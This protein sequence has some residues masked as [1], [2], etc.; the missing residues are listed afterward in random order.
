MAKRNNLEII[1]QRAKSGG[2]K[3]GEHAERDKERGRTH[4]NETTL[5]AQDHVLDVYLAWC[6]N[7]ANGVP[8]EQCDTRFLRTFGGQKL[9]DEDT[10]EINRWLKDD[11]PYEKTKEGNHYCYNMEK[12]KFN[13]QPGDLDRLI[14]QVWSGQDTKHIHDKNRLQFH[15][16]LLL[17][18]QSGARRGALLKY[19]V[20]YKDIHLVLS[21]RQGEPWFF[22]NLAQRHV[23]NNKDPDLRT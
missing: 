10:A 19:G 14:D 12:P 2:Y 21:Q 6:S 3:Y 16:L 1:A 18:C 9:S 23:K 8:F 11:L 20:P 13:F 7:R 22:Y 5:A 17:F 15:L 4:Y